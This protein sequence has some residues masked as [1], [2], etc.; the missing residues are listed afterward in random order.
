MIVIAILAILAIALRAGCTHVKKDIAKPQQTAVKIMVQ[1]ELKRMIVAASDSLYQLQFSSFI[2]NV[3]SGRGLIKDV[4]LI[5]DSNVYQKLVARHK[6]PNIRLNMQAD[7]MVIDHFAFVKTNNGRQLVI[8][9][10]LVQNPS[11][12]VTYIPQPYN[13]TIHSSSPSLLAATIKKLFQISVVKHMEMKHLNVAIAYHT[14]AFTKTTSLKNIN[15]DMDGMNVSMVKENDSSKQHSVIEVERY[16]L[17]TADNLYDIIISNIRLEPETGTASIAKAVIQPAYDKASFFKKVSKANDRFYFVYNNLLLQGIDINRLLHQQQIK[18]RKMVVGSSFTDIYTDYKLRK[19]KPPL[20]KHGFPQELLQKLAVDITIDT[21]LMHNGELKYEIKAKTSGDTA[22]FQ[23]SNME[24]RIENIT[25][26]PAAK[27]ANHFTTAITSGRVMDAG[28]ITSTLKFDLTDKNG[29][30]T[31]YSVLQPMNGTVLNPLT[32]ALAMTEIQSLDIQKMITTING[33]ETSASGNIDFYYKNMKIALLKKKND[34]YKK[35]G[36]IS[37]VSNA[38]VADD[39]PK[40]NGKFKK[41]PINIKRHPTDSFFAYLWAAM[42]D[43]MTANM[44]GLD[45]KNR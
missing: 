23:L 10:V 42:F 4:R 17:K 36:F 26:N 24:S 9:N 27:T 20:R 13:D 18:V 32:K 14:P 34:A 19:R 6:A 33:N 30:F 8:N 21:M 2:L 7:S 3:D 11:V 41:G 38:F 39:N 29:A 35:I 12:Y 37:W 44:A 45:K 5:A 1:D 22:L 43:G 31:L 16:H 15:V 28:M 25:N 40:K